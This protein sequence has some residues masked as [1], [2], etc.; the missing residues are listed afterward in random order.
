MRP[1]SKIKYNEVRSRIKYQINRRSNDPVKKIPMDSQIKGIYISRYNATYKEAVKKF[2][3]ITSNAELEESIKSAYQEAEKQRNILLEEWN[4]VPERIRPIFDEPLK[5]AQIRMEQ[6]DHEAIMD[7][8]ESEFEE[9]I[10]FLASLAIQ[11]I[12]HEY[13]REEE[14]TDYSRFELHPLEEED[15]EE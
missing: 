11:M 5:Y 15:D 12:Y 1:I 13:V 4:R 10:D 6:L 8:L 7:K 9:M 3:Q 2:E 14:L